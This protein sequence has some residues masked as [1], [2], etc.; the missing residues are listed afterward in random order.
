MN[1]YQ[2]GEFSIN[3]QLGNY[4][5]YQSDAAIFNGNLVLIT[6]Y[7]PDLITNN[8]QLYLTTFP[9]DKLIEKSPTLVEEP[10]NDEA[11]KDPANWNTVNLE[12][13]PAH[14]KPALAVFP[15]DS[16]FAFIC[17]DIVSQYFP[18]VPGIFALRYP[19]IDEEHPDLNNKW[20]LPIQMYESDGINV[21]TP[22]VKGNLYKDISTTVVG[23]NLIIVTCASAAPFSGA[24]N[25]KYKPWDAKGIGT[26]VGVYDKNKIDFTNNAWKAEFSTYLPYQKGFNQDNANQVLTE[27]YS[28]VGSTLDKNGNPLP[29]YYLL[30]LVMNGQT[31]NTMPDLSAFYAAIN[32]SNNGLAP[33]GN[34]TPMGTEDSSPLKFMNTDSPSTPFSIADLTRDA[35]GR[36]RAWLSYNGNKKFTAVNMEHHGQ[37]DSFI[38]VTPTTNDVIPSETSL[39]SVSPSSSV[40]YIALEA[41][42]ITNIKTQKQ[43]APDLSAK[44]YPVYEFVFYGEYPKCQVNRVGT[45][46]SVSD[47]EDNLRSPKIDPIHPRFIIGGIFNGPIPFPIVNYENIDPGSSENIAGSITYGRHNK[48]IKGRSA[49]RSLSIGL[50]AEGKTT[51]GVGIAFE[52]SFH[53]GMGSV[54]EDSAETDFVSNI[55]QEAPVSFDL[56]KKNPKAVPDGI[57]RVLAAILKVTAF[58]YRDIYGVSIDST[59]DNQSGSMK[60]GSIQIGLMDTGNLLSFDPYNVT[61][62]DLESYMPEA[63]NAKMK[64]LGYKGKALG[65]ADDNNYFG[66]VICQNALPIGNSDYMEMTWLKSSKNSSNFSQINTSYKETNWSFDASMYAGLSGGGG[67][68]LFWLGEK[69]ELSVLAGAE[70]SRDYSKS[71]ETETEWGIEI[72]DS[73]GPS[74]NE[75]L[76]AVKKY[77]FRIYFLPVPC[78]P[79]L[80]PPTYWTTELLDNLPADSKTKNQ[81][82]DKSACWRIF[83]AV[84]EIEYNNGNVSSYNGLLDK[85]SVYG[86]DNSMAT[87]KR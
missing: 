83:Y 86:I 82:D 43:G 42:Y 68:D 51:E 16:M 37:G 10:I 71:E 50:E 81:I 85:P 9:L 53:K 73:W 49:E 47:P 18:P 12:I 72:S 31:K 45:I 76:D 1:A 4:N 60:A 74:T 25:A 52:A 79:S 15:A 3:K 28:R 57:I 22:Y 34:F 70:L 41:Q 78:A 69:F 80:L 24:A 55:T 32:L 26:F 65:Y 67:F 13:Y 29:E 59:S 36:L 33:L 87:S 21:P 61:P 14:S 64:A 54:Q 38:E 46:Q 84:K 58:S 77:I 5:N 6:S 8:C 56:E 62:G 20:S 35:A 44:N 7:G 66:D 17:P 40:S 2:S 39:Y 63:I 19:L 27:W 48:D 75:A 23:G 30:V 11:L